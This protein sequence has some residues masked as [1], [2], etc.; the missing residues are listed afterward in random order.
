MPDTMVFK[1]PP[2]ARDDLKSA[3]DAH[4]RADESDCIKR[5]LSELDLGDQMKTNIHDYAAKLVEA[6]RAK[7]MNQGG[8]DAFLH[9]YG[10]SSQEGVLLMCVAE[11]LL[12]VPDDDTRER[13]I[14]DKLGTADWEKHL[15][16]SSSLF[17][18]AS[19]WALMM[20]GKVVNM[21]NIRGRSPE[22]QVRRLVA[23]LGEPVVRESVNQAMKIMGKQFVMGRTI[24][25][26]LERARDWE[27]RGY[28]YSYDMLGEAARTM[29]DAKRY[30]KSY[31]DAIAAIGKTADGRGPYN[32]PGI[33]VKL[34]ALHPRYELGQVGRVMDEL[35]PRLRALCMDAAKYDIGL[36][37]DA[38]EADRLD[39]SLDCI[40]AISGDPDLKDWQGFG[41]VVQAYQKRAPFVLDYLADM[42]KRH[43][44][45]FMVRLVKGAYW[46]ME[47]KRA[48]ELGLKGY[49]VFTRKANTDVSYLAC[50]RKLFANT[51]AFYPQLA[52]HN[53][54][55]ISAVL[56]FAGNNRDFEFQRLH[57]MGEE[58]YEHAI[59]HDK[60]GTGCRIYAPVGQ[61]EDLL[62][63]LVR[64]LLE[65]GA[66]SSFVN[67]LQDAATPVDEII[68]DPIA[69]VA[70]YTR[71]PHPRIPMPKDIYGPERPNAK[72]VDLS[73]R[74]VLNQLAEDMPKIFDTS[75]RAGPIVGGQDL[76]GQDARD[77]TSPQRLSRTFGQASEATDAD[78]D[79]AL[80]MAAKAGKDWAATSAEERAACL[81][82][83][84]DLMESEMSCLMALCVAEAGKTVLD[85]VAEIRE[86]IDFCRY[87]ALC[88][89]NDL[90]RGVRLRAPDGQG[91][92]IALSGGGV[93]TCISPWN[94]PFAIFAGQVTAALA[95]GNAVIAKPAEQTP[96]I[97]AEAVRLLHRAGIPGEV[98]HLLPGDGARVGGKLVKDPRVTGVCFTGSTEVARI[99]NRTLASRDGVLPPLIAETGGQNAMIVDSTAL[100]EQVTRD[101]LM[102]S[103][104]S[105]GQRC[106]AL[107][108]LFVQDDVAKRTMHML[109]G[110]MDELRVSDPA[111]LSTDVGPVI[112]AE[113]QDMLNGH[114]KRMLGEGNE[115]NRTRLGAGTEDGCFVTPAAFEI[116]N[117][118]V[119]Q[120]EVFGPVLHV[121][122]YKAS[123]LDN[124][125][126]AINATGC[127]LTFGV[128][129]RIDETW[130]KVFHGVKCGNTYVNRNQI[131][132][133][134]GVQPFGG[135]GLSGTGPKAGGPQYLHRFVTETGPAV[136]SPGGWS[137]LT[138]D[139]KLAA[140]ASIDKAMKTV[141]GVGGKWDV[142]AEDRA[143]IIEDV[144][145]ALDA[146]DGDAALSDFE[147]ARSASYLRAYAA[148]VDA[149][150][151]E[152][153]SLPGP[154]GERNELSMVPRGPVVCLAAGGGN[155][156]CA[157]AAQAGAA[158]ATGNAA[159]LFHPDPGV[160]EALAKLFIK[161]GVDKNAI[162]VVETGTDAT[163]ADVVG[164]AG[165]EAVAY[166]GPLNFAAEI[167]RTL[168]AADAAIR[169]VIYFREDPAMDAG[170][171]QPLAGSPNYVERFVHERSL[172]IDT[173]ASGGNASLLSIEDGGTS[174]PGEA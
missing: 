25:D 1:K 57:G 112:D 30:F 153:V 28:S 148:H 117:I 150:F 154:T 9:E 172:S 123:K 106:S 119:L 98:L 118:G 46:D 63:Y 56:E 42:G 162:A 114:I 149:H 87:Y 60:I 16:R 73:D 103:F 36:N 155:G 32:G 39:I 165:I 116:D 20:T 74:V 159:V 75:W 4:Y 156:I 49:P 78:I 131:G 137:E 38:E 23:R 99:I 54:H 110:A 70:G 88:A 109:A 167:N 3:I 107:R 68:A 35:V 128:H 50:A 43:G 8:I 2:A 104:Q 102:S 79:K 62:A 40:E 18:N 12:R 160:A 5:L 19:T 81:E 141:T 100:T 126:D 171:G 26:A 64:R 13:L 80:T 108:V 17:V 142:P 34:S 29:E 143:D 52:T 95:A 115:I 173:T 122:R 161:A 14:R 169:P 124:V 59:E 61:H 113:A 168:A 129:T 44:R 132:A 58:L 69:Q 174:L 92:E 11:A 94:F 135:Q 147:G 170:A 33:S 37:I 67:R 157:L 71:I 65:N 125:I 66:N 47:V 91:G 51:D 145:D 140:K 77:V 84:A 121:V 163:L 138:M 146:G 22:A 101:V 158:L 15:G 6:A 144:A 90:A 97:A 130:R 86:A 48:Q 133:I 27:A 139:D 151:C 10:L 85:S 21:H 53:A 127:G 83:A 24:E 31:K 93:Y 89:R 76:D 111:Y 41:V 55:T 166:A 105:A 120:R 164:A 45:R 152:P 72:G 96:L 7:T 82:R 134:V 136:N